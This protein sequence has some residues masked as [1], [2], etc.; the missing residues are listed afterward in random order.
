MGLSKARNAQLYPLFSATDISVP[1]SYSP[2]LQPL[3]IPHLL[4]L[5]KLVVSGVKVD[6]LNHQ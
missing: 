3:C 1:L 4:F 6:S 2:R 5:L